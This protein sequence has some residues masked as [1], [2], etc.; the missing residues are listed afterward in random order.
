[1]A[2]DAEHAI[3]QQV[4]EISQIALADRDGDVAVLKVYM[5]ESGTHDGSPIVTVAAYIGR[6]KAW[7]AWTEKWVRALRPIKVYHAVDAQN[8]TGEFEN[9]TDDQVAEL[10]K[11][12]L[13]ITA[14]API[15]AT[16]VAMDLRVFEAAMKGRDD[17]REVF[18]TPYIA[19]FQWAVQIILN[20]AFETRSAERIAF[21]HENNDYHGQAYEAFDWVKSNSNRGE[22]I[23]SL[24]FGAKKDYPP[25]QTADILAYETN[26]RLRNLDA[27]ARRPWAALKGNSF[28]AH[29]GATNMDYLI[30]TLEKIKAGGAD[31]ISPLSETA[32]PQRAFVWRV[33]ALVAPKTQ[34]TRS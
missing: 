18:G 20:I 28:A 26:K 17:L 19:C 8:L 13:P 22:N 21:I 16:S 34:R 15:A 29:Y 3:A 5:D 23:I 1:M 12:L 32:R 9:W 24:T 2:F 4:W 10:V 30:S 6:P 27:P 25:L 7:R 11:K 31:D 33:G 14:H